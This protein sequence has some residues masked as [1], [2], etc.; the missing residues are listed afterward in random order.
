[1][2]LAEECSHGSSS[3]LEARWAMQASAPWKSQQQEGGGQKSR[4]RM[5]DKS[6]DGSE[7]AECGID[8]EKKTLKRRRC[9]GGILT[10]TLSCG[11]LVD[12]LELPRGEA[13]DVVY[14]FVLDV[15][16]ELSARQVQVKCVGYDNACR[17]LAMAERCENLCSP[18]TNKVT[19][20]RIVL[21]RFH[22]G[23]HSWCLRHRPQAP[24]KLNK[25][26]TNKGNVRG[27]V[28]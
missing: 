4:G 21:D 17:L 1:M 16:K 28:C 14:T 7:L 26:N 2:S 6:T 13:L 3:C 20:C 23:H 9:T 27:K 25:R 18:W 5:A 12:W 10:A 11:Q 19:E 8:K 24:G 22:K 15:I